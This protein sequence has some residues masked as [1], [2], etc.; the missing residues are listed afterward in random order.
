M[1]IRCIV[2]TVLMVHLFVVTNAQSVNRTYQTRRADMKPKIDGRPF[3]QV[4]ERAE[5]GSEFIVLRPNNGKPESKGCSTVVKILYDDDALYVAAFLYDDGKVSRQFSKRDEVNVQADLFSFWVNTYN[6]QIEQ[7]RFYVTSAGAVADSRYV[8]GDE[9]FSYNVIFE[10][11]TSILKEGWFVEMVIPYQA[12]RFVKSEVQTWSF[13]AF[14]R[15]NRLNQTSTFNFV[16]IEKGNEAQYD[17][18]LIGIEK[19]KPPIRLSL[20]PYASIQSKKLSDQSEIT[21]NLGMD[22]KVGLSDAFTLDATLIPDFGQVAFDDVEL[23]L[24]PFEQVFEERRPFFT[25]GTELFSKGNI[26]FSRRIG[27]V[28]FDYRE[29]S[30]TLLANEKL[31]ANPVQSQLLN[32]FKLSG[33]T[34]KK[35]GVG[36][37]NAITGPTRA[38]ILDTINNSSRFL[39]THPLTNY[40]MLVLDQQYGANSSFYFSNASTVRKGYFEDANVSSVGFNHFDKQNRYNYS[41]EANV[42]ARFQDTG[43]NLGFSM[44][45]RWQKVAGKWRYGISQGFVSMS[46]NPNDLGLQFQNNI[47]SVY[48]FGSYNQFKPKGYFNNYTIDFSI[49]HSR[50]NMPGVH[51]FTEIGINPNFQTRNFWQGGFFVTTFT[52]EYDFF[53]SRIVLQPVRYKPKVVYGIYLTSDIRKKVSVFANVNAEN[54]FNDPENRIDFKVR[55]SFRFTDR[56]F[57]QF[58]SFWQR[59]Q[60]RLS[61]VTIYNGESLL[62]LRSTRIVENTMSAVYSFDTKKSINLRLRNFW[63]SAEFSDDLQRLAGDGETVPYSPLNTITPD[64]DFNIWNFDCSFE[65]QFAPASSLIFLYRNAIS[66]AMSISNLRYWQSLNLLFQNPI[67][68]TLS[69]RIVYFLDSNKVLRRR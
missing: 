16:D 30:D 1:H 20:F 7:T 2:Y 65:W 45:N 67:E 4:W 22:V 41:S 10:A 57:I 13:N 23:N 24:S 3:E 19:I 49:F 56:F 50:T 9:D 6:N 11:K 54:R 37:L 42:S 5:G 35:L 31:I 25:E 69:L 39:V 14:R 21:V 51:N 63:S 64:T 27:Q 66:D 46:Y 32:A 60:N 61:F 28:P 18:S 59:R 62:S 68:H 36:V 58:E 38:S 43:T 47:N 52:R 55:P 34:G 44:K 29:V 15:I 53:E 33:R 48:L 40:N 12:L 8:N 26:F 17:A